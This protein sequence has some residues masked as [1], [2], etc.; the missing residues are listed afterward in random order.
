MSHRRLSVGKAHMGW[1]HVKQI[2]PSSPRVVSGPRFGKADRMTQLATFPR[3]PTGGRLLAD[4][5][6]SDSRT[7]ARPRGH[8]A[9]T[10][11]VG[12]LRFERCSSEGFRAARIAGA[13]HAGNWGESVTPPRTGWRTD[14]RP[15]ASVPGL[16]HNLKALQ[17]RRAQDPL[18]L[19]LVAQAA[20]PQNLLSFTNGKWNRDRL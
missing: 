3:S 16:P 17:S 12:P 14:A 7:N 19:E 8:K 15:G 11:D 10:L 13:A 9:H 20:D 18:N 1:F 4:L 2:L 5:V 6:W